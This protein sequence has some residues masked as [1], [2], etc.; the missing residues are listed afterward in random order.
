VTETPT[1]STSLP[2]SETDRAQCNAKISA[3]TYWHFRRACDK[4]G[5]SIASVLERMMEC[6]TSSVE[7]RAPVHVDGQPCPMS[8]LIE[9]LARAAEQYIRRD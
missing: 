8:Q 7:G 1:K 4:R 9:N 3:L 6:Y 5:E 2:P